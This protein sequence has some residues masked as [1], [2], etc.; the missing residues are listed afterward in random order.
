M[1]FLKSEAI[2]D[3][4]VYNIVPEEK[5]CSLNDRIVIFKLFQKIH[6]S[7]K[8]SPIKNISLNDIESGAMNVRL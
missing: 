5:T 7:N 2:C 8:S 1:N 3:I 4:S 6:N